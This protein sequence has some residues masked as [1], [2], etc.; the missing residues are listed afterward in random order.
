MKK[1]RGWPEFPAFLADCREAATTDV[2]VTP[3]VAAVILG[4]S[5][6]SIRR[7]LGRESIHSWAWH[8][9][10]EFHATEIFVSVQSLVLFGLKRGR[11][12]E[13]DD[14]EPLRAV[15]SREEYA[16]MRQEMS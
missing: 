8:E 1:Y 9:P 6:V 13:Y 11:L 2:L 12:G 4:Y 3:P 16:Q 15:I 5:K 14:E 10:D 7:L